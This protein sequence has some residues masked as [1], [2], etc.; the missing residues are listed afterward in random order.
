MADAPEQGELLLKLY[1]LRRDPALREARAW[2]VAEFDPQGPQDFGALMRAGFA[3]SAKYRMVTTYWEMAASLVNHGAI[4][5]AMF[6]AANTEHVA[7]FAKIAPFLAE[8]RTLFREPRY[9]VELETLMASHP[10]A[11]GIFERRRGLL[12]HW[13]VQR[14]QPAP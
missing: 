14:A 12:K 9:L 1:D 10:E 6:H 5:P 3:A 8:V 2:Y 13:V 7:I 11:P 4:A